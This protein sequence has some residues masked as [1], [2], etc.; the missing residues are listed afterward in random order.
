MQ[1]NHHTQTSNVTAI[2]PTEKL[3]V[4]NNG[5]E[6]DNIV[7]G[8]HNLPISLS[9]NS[10]SVLILNTSSPNASEILRLEMQLWAKLLGPRAI[11]TFELIHPAM[12]FQPYELTSLVHC[13]A[14]TFNVHTMS[15]RQHRAV[16]SVNEINDESLALLKGLGFTQIQIQVAQLT[17][18][19]SPEFHHRC[20]TI[21][22]YHFDFFGIQLAHTDCLD[23]LAPR[24]REF[25]KQCHPD[26]IFVGA[27]S[28][29]ISLCDEDKQSARII[30]DEGNGRHDNLCLGPE[31]V[32][33]IN[34]Y[35]LQHLCSPSRYK[36]ALSEGRLPLHIKTS[37]ST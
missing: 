11:D 32:S 28:L 1:T 27:R 19:T 14:S 23:Q 31:S 12:C 34:G 35:T 10:E 15:K 16:C 22:D 6:L 9:I 25:V 18:L 4:A 2:R 33:T 3:P 24:I 36:Q 13:V 21:K 29:N 17:S 26:Y 7:T 5:Q 37:R 8:A 20:K 30:V